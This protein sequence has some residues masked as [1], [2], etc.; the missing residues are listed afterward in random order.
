MIHLFYG[1][2]EHF[3]GKNGLKIARKTC[4]ILLDTHVSGSPIIQNGKLVGAVTHV[5]IDDS[6]S[7]YGIFAEN[8]LE[9]A[10][11]TGE[12]NLKEAS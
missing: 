11:S 9:K 3:L 10:Q 1:Q 7:G 8:M 5:M 6:T 2:N 4:C 12:E